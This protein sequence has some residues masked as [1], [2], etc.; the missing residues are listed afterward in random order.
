MRRC[1]HR[2]VAEDQEEYEEEM[3]ADERRHK[4]EM[5]QPHQRHE[6]LTEELKHTAARISKVALIPLMSRAI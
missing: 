6:Q 5:R 2:G 4:G 1:I 3:V